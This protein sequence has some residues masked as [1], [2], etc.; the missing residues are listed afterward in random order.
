MEKDPISRNNTNA[1]DVFA[2][3]I[4]HYDQLSD[5]DKKLYIQDLLEVC[6]NKHWLL[7]IN[8]DKLKDVL[9]WSTRHDSLAVVIMDELKLKCIKYH[10]AYLWD[11]HKKCYSEKRMDG[12]WINEHGMSFRY[13]SRI[14]NEK[15]P[16]CIIEGV[17][18][19]I[20]LELLRVNYLCLESAQVT[21]SQDWTMKTFFRHKSVVWLGDNDE[22]GEQCYNK[23]TKM[24]RDFANELK[25]MF[26]IDLECDYQ[27]SFKDISDF[28]CSFEDESTP[29]EDFVKYTEKI[30]K[31]IFKGFLARILM[32][33]SIKPDVYKYFQPTDSTM[34]PLPYATPVIVYGKGSVGKTTLM[35]HYAIELAL[36]DSEKRMFLW[37][38]ENLNSPTADHIRNIIK[39]KYPNKENEILA[40]LAKKVVIV[41]QRT[42]SFSFLT[43]SKY[44]K[45]P[46]PPRDFYK[47][48]D[49]LKDFDFLVFDPLVY[50]A[51]DL[52]LNRNNHFSSFFYEM[53]EWAV[54][55]N[56]CIIFLHRQNKTEKVGNQYSR[57]LDENPI[58]N[59]VNLIFHVDSVSYDHIRVR[60]VKNNIG[61]GH[62]EN[63]PY[64]QKDIMDGRDVKIHK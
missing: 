51:E 62:Q 10:K 38:K 12:K 40:K 25:R 18:D 52:D 17:H 24:I 42:H 26:W 59:P 36:S 58:F 5:R 57:L 4:L 45:K 19:L 2:T 22:A 43:T 31:I 29:E 8:L 9:Y 56:K 49:E 13:T 32:L 55:D 15:E 53:K 39:W 35:L 11:T 64:S 23:N 60:V 54:E 48:Q 46:Y 21:L 61:F 33:N 37:L 50:F 28:V 7:E 14:F 16:I 63:S 3:T 1:E 20:T 47:L 27:C 6:G 44:S 41:D 30:R 34:Y